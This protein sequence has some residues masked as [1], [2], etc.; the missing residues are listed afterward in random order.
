MYL[1]NRKGS[2]KLVHVIFLLRYFNFWQ[3]MLNGCNGQKYT[4]T[5]TYTN[6]KDNNKNM[7]KFIYICI[8][9]YNENNNMIYM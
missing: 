5:F 4:E 7:N 8:Q 1:D 6:D 9:S 3:S 2:K